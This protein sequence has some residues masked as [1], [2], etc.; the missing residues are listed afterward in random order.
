MG[1][2]KALERVPG[3]A[4]VTRRVNRVRVACRRWR[5]VRAYMRVAHHWRLGEGGRSVRFGIVN[6]AIAREQLQKKVLIDIEDGEVQ[7]NW[8]EQD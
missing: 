3:V 2:G 1:V 5:L 8:P 4:R 6:Q 7:W